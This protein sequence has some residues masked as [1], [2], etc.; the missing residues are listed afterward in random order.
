MTLSTLLTIAVPEIIILIA[1]YLSI[2][3]FVHVSDFVVSL[4]NFSIDIEIVKLRSHFLFTSKTFLIFL[5]VWFIQNISFTNFQI[6]Q[7]V[8]QAQEI[9]VILIVSRW[10]SWWFFIII[11][12]L[13][14][15]TIII[16]HCL[17]HSELT[18]DMVIFYNIKIWWSSFLERK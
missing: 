11:F 9:F 14:F 4:L 10:W 16:C 17:S 15:E 18:F 12:I 6:K 8:I 7:I 5:K 3:L 1:I 2:S 13:N